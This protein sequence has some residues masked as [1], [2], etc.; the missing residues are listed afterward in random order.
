MTTTPHSHSHSDDA[1]SHAPHKHPHAD[2]EGDASSVT[3][4]QRLAMFLEAH[5][6][7]V[8]LHMPDEDGEDEERE[9]GEDEEEAEIANEPSL[10]VE[11]D[12]AMAKINLK[13]LVSAQLS[14]FDSV[15]SEGVLCFDFLTSRC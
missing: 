14:S 5:F 7:D 9:K 6:G 1:H 12:E 3:R 13:T 15:D 11:L 4:I 10:L 2:P 8:E